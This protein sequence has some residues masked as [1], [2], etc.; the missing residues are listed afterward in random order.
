[1]NNEKQIAEN[2]PIIFNEG[3]EIVFNRA[4][5]RFEG[6]SQKKID[7]DLKTANDFLAS[8]S[9]LSDTNQ[10]KQ[11]VALQ[12][13]LRE[14]RTKLDKKRKGLGQLFRDATTYING[15]AKEIIGPAQEAENRL[16]EL[17]NAHDAEVERIAQEE[18]RKEEER[19][20]KIE[21]RICFIRDLPSECI[22]KSVITIDSYVCDL[23]SAEEDFQEFEE[24]GK[25]AKEK[26]L[27]QLGKLLES[28]ITEEKLAEDWRIAEEKRK[29]REAE[30]RAEFERQQRELAVQQQA[31]QITVSVAN[32]VNATPIEIR[33]EIERLKKYAHPAVDPALYAASMTAVNILE[34]VIPAAEQR[35]ACQRA[36]DFGQTVAALS[37]LLDKICE[38]RSVIDI[39]ETVAEAIQDGEIPFV[40]W[41]NER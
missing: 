32:F 8:A 37:D 15:R 2:L 3:N 16:K 31:A 17:R 20:N 4:A 34:S 10:Y 7:Q 13:S 9:D 33:N 28:A 38:Y 12:S 19:V 21:S 39:A 18:A 22:G 30:E 29:Q 40:R 35:E 26:T 24:A 36:E 5:V 41:G 6:I 1:M 27:E 11:L 23:I 25:A 14:H